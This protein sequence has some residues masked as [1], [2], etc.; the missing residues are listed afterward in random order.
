MS[1]II[2]E[3][4]EEHVKL[5]KHL[6]WSIDDNKIIVNKG[7]DGDEIAPPFGFDTI[8]EAIDLILNGKSKN[9]DPFSQEDFVDYT[10]EQKAAWDKLYSELP[11]ALDVILYNGHFELGKYKTRWHLRDWKKIKG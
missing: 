6:R 1:A 7:D 11:M 2:F 5:L 9:I 4:K 3:L 10:D 8:Y